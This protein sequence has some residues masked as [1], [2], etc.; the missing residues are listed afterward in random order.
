MSKYTTEVRFICEVNSGF[1]TDEL[2]SHTPDEIIAAARTHIFNFSYPIYDTT[3]KPELETKILKH[4]YTREIAAETVSLWKLW[5]ND[6]LNLIMPKYNKL[7]QAEAE[8]VNKQLKNIDIHTVLDRD[9]TARKNSD[10]TRTDNL[11]RTPNITHETTDRYSDTPQG[12][13]SNVDNQTYLTDYRKIT[14]RETGT[15]QNTGTQETEGV[16]TNSH[17]QDETENKTGYNGSLIYGELLSEYAEKVI[18]ID[19]MII[20]DLSDLFMKLW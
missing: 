19:Y 10:Y 15:E 17:S 3:H 1:S 11:Q 5:L 9:E 13:I 7:Y 16:E 12:T 6:T 2:S 14:D 8:T 20:N 4:Y 18:N